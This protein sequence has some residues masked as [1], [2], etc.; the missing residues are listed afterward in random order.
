MRHETNILFDKISSHAFV[1][2]WMAGLVY[3]VAAALDLA[4]GVFCIVYSIALSLPLTT[5]VIGT[6]G[7]LSFFPLFLFSFDYILFLHLSLFSILDL[8]TAAIVLI[9][10]S[11]YQGLVNGD[12][13]QPQNHLHNGHRKMGHQPPTT[14]TM[15]RPCPQTSPGHTYIHTPFLSAIPIRIIASCHPR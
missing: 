8:I 3:R 6:L 5:C 1:S 9:R 15:A 7:F 13:A 2:F 10:I 14:D 4:S 12:T 11:P